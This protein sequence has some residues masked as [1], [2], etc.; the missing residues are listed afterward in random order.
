MV[1][2]DKVVIV[3]G[4]L[5]GLA[6]AVTLQEALG[7]VDLHLVEKGVRLGGRTSSVDYGG[8]EVDVG[9]HLHVHAFENYRNFIHKIGLADRL[10]TQSRL[11]AE[12]RD[13]SGRSGHIRS[14]GLFPP[15]HLFTSLA[16]FPFISRSGKV[17]AVLPALRATLGLEGSEPRDV[18][19]GDWLK[20]N[21]VRG[22]CVDR[23]WDAFIVPTLNATSRDVSKD[24]GMMI[25]KRVLLD[26][27]G[28][29]LGYLEAPLSRIGDAAK[30]L[31]ESR[32]GMVSTKTSASA[33]KTDPD[34]LFRVKL[35]NGDTLSAGTLVL[36]TPSYVVSD[37]LSP[38]IKKE[39]T[40]PFWDLRWNSIVNVHLFYQRPVTEDD[41]FGLIDGVGGWVFNV[42]WDDFQP[43][44][45]LCVSISDPGE[46][47][48]LSQDGLCGLVIDQLETVIPATGSTPLDDCLVV[49]RPRA[50]VLPSPGSDA[51]RPPTSPPADNLFFAGDWTDTGWPSTMEGAVKSGMSAGSEVAAQVSGEVPRP[52]E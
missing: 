5:A 16:R 15:L 26:K 23:L 37:L 31:I 12:F 48:E 2:H 29:R 18:S 45:H 1:R 36:A 41:F 27:Q 32:G 3:G 7:E 13:I 39:L 28:G 30:D 42:S 34:G 52:R 43:G 51:F 38:A 4:G 24:M 44:T 20:E 50:T 6:T 11:S 19:F 47:F 22:T 14:T 33:V 8:G 25:L 46:L 35:A 10:F 17:G 40:T 21:G 9:Q 49:K